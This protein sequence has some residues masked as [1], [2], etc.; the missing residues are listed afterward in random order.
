MEVNVLK[1]NVLVVLMLFLMI[2]SQAL[3]GIEGKLRIAIL[4]FRQ[5]ASNI[6]TAIDPSLIE[7]KLSSDLLKTGR[8][9]IIEQTDVAKAL[10]ELNITSSDESEDIDYK[11]LGK[12]LNAQAIITG[13]LYSGEKTVI[14]NSKTDF[15][16]YLLVGAILFPPLIFAVQPNED[17][18]YSVKVN[19]FSVSVRAIDP[20]TGKV[21]AGDEVLEQDAIDLSKVSRN[22]YAQ[23]LARFP[24]MGKVVNVDNGSV[25]LDTGRDKGLAAGDILEVFR[26]GRLIEEGASNIIRLPDEKIGEIEVLNAAKDYSEC[27][28]LPHMTKDVVNSGYRVKLLP[29]ELFSPN[30]MVRRNPENNTRPWGMGD[31]FI[32]VA[33]GP[34]CV[35]QNP[36]GIIRS[37]SPQ[38]QVGW[39]VHSNSAGLWRPNAGET[40]NA[41]TV[42]SSYVE[43]PVYPNEFNGVFPLKEG[44]IGL[45]LDVDDT[46]I[47]NDEFKYDDG[48]INVGLYGSTALNPQLSVGAG[49][50]LRDRWIGI[51]STSNSVDNSDQFRGSGL[52]YKLAALYTPSPQVGFGGVLNYYTKSSGTLRKTGLVPSDNSYE[53]DGQSSLGVGFSF[54]LTPKL[55]LALDVLGYL[56]PAWYDARVGAEYSLT[57]S[58]AFRIGTRNKLVRIPDFASDLNYPGNYDINSNIY[59]CGIG[60]NS[61]NWFMDIAGEY[62][63]YKGTNSIIYP[64]T[65]PGSLSRTLMSSYKEVRIKIGAGAKF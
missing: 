52:G 2:A 53:I 61:G 22:I 27:R 48:G 45:H 17:H 18:P 59:T 44:A 51:H 26:P 30:T 31:A 32:G 28:V 37:S 54:K 62:E 7:E 25:Y 33:A 23:L 16:P 46:R 49:I 29:V 40:I 60:I 35:D 24:V 43:N 50:I 36:A 5:G 39:N 41:K 65:T 3:A 1:R 64:D 58:I 4:D 57:N 13:S 15:N 56:T 34:M 10:S 11:K 63:V 21:I 47:Y 14:K 9:D 38:I 12:I 20:D 42:Y 6:S 8:F 19:T 55:I